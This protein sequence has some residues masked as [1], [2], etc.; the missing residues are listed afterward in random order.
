MYTRKNF[1]EIAR[2]LKS[3]EP[4]DTTVPANSPY[5]VGRRH[6]WQATI[7]EFTALFEIDNPKFDRERF[8]MA[9]GILESHRADHLPPTL[10]TKET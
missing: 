6:Q 10:Y 5:Y 3:L 4:K 2:L 9:C 7:E 8:M 1:N